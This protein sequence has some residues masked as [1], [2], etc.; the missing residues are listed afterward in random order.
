MTFLENLDDLGIEPD[1]EIMAAIVG[2]EEAE[3]RLEAW[4]AWSL[5]RR[6]EQP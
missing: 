3:R 2:R 1:V 4:R 5:D 6:A